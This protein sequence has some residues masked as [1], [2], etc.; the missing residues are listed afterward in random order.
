MTLCESKFTHGQFLNLFEGHC[1]IPVQSPVLRAHFPGSVGKSPRRV[2]E[3]GTVLFC[4]CFSKVFHG[5]FNVL[6][7]YVNLS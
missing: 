2:N 4:Y 5:L 3:D 7:L 1:L 6:S